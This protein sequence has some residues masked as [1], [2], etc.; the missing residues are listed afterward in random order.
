MTLQIR[1]FDV[2]IAM[3]ELTRLSTFHE[4]SQAPGLHGPQAAFQL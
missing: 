1:E 4:V 2:R 3:N